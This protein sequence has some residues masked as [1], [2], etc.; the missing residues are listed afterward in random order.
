MRM[1]NRQIHDSVGSS[2]KD[3][4]SDDF[5]RTGAIATEKLLSKEKFTGTIWEPACG[6]GDISQVL[7]SK[8]KVIS[9]DLIVRGYGMGDCDFL[10]IRPFMG[11]NNIVTNPP[12]KIAEEFVLHALEIT[13]SCGKIAM[14][15]RTLWLEGS[16]R[17]D[18]LFTKYPPTRVWVLSSRPPM[19]RGK[20]TPFQVGLVSFSWFVW[21]L[22]E[23][24]NQTT[25]L[26]WI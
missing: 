13:P 8:N 18:R 22:K 3:R 17:R 4:D 14:F 16:G 7:L 1:T 23:P 12:Y 21:D 9:S 15:C 24:N 5:Y 10:T 19:A 25:T 11:F 2:S 6:I 20:N 26:G